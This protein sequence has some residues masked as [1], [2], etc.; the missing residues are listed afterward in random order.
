[1]PRVSHAGVEAEVCHLDIISIQALKAPNRFPAMRR[2]HQSRHVITATT[3][4]NLETRD[5]PSRSL[6]VCSIIS[7]YSRTALASGDLVD[8]IATAGSDAGSSS[9]H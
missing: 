2:W 3:P 1:M 8:S 7:A 9:S 5:V 4:A 6:G